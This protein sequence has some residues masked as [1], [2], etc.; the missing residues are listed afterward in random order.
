VDSSANV[1][2]GQPFTY[3]AFACCTDVRMVS[4]HTRS[5][6][7]EHKNRESP[8]IVKDSRKALT[9]DTC[10]ETHRVKI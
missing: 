1:D 8:T 3:M 2:E 4:V 5:M 10:E 9:P 6:K 7:E